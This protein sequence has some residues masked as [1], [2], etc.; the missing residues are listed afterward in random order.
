MPDR[1]VTPPEITEDVVYLKDVSPIWNPVLKDEGLG[2]ADLDTIL[3]ENDHQI[4]KHGIT[5]HRLQKWF[6]I[7]TVE[8]GELAEA[9]LTEKP[10]QIVEEA[11]HV[12]TISLK[13]GVMMKK[14]LP[15][16]RP[17]PD[18]QVVG[19]R[20]KDWYKRCVPKCKR[21]RTVYLVH[22]DRQKL[23]LCVKCEL[24]QQKE[25]RLQEK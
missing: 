17:N 20:M 6:T 24:K 22:S 18:P 15:A 4:E 11:A 14:L 13:I 25:N 10:A 16:P 23:G 9:I 12:S 2:V 5:E 8:M 19:K 3:E 1:D 7:L 21:C